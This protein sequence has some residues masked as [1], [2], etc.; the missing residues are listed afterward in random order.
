MLG[1]AA[2][3]GPAYRSALLALGL[4]HLLADMIARLPHD[5]HQVGLAP[6]DGGMHAGRAA[7]PTA[8]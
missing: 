4:V 7:S 8:D 5:Q 6:C 2:R 3:M 1:A